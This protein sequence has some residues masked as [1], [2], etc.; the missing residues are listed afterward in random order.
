M[1]TKIRLSQLLVIGCFFGFFLF[2]LVWGLA[3]PDR[4][5]SAA[6]NRSLAQRPAMRRVVTDFGGFARDFESYAADQFPDREQLIGVYTA[7]ELA[8]GKKFA[9]KAYCLQGG[10]LL[11]KPT[12]TKPADLSALQ[13]ALAQAGALDRPLVW[14]VLPLKN[15]ALYDLEPAYFSDE[16]GKTNKQALTAALAQVEGL[17]V[18][19]AEAP[20]VTGTLADRE[21]YFY[22]TDFHWNARGAFAAAQEIARIL[23][24]PA[25]FSV[26]SFARGTV[27][28]IGFQITEQD[29]M[30]GKSL[31]EY[32]KL[33]PN[34]L[35]LCAA[36]RGGEVLVPNGHFVPQAGDRVYA[37]GTPTETARVLRSMGRD[38]SPIRQL[39]VIGGG[40]IALYLAWALDGMGMHIT[41]VEQNEEKCMAIAEKLP[42]AT[43]LHGDGT[44]HDLLESEGIFDADAFV[45]LTGRD[46][47]NLLMALTAKDSGV[48]KVLPKMSRP[49]YTALVHDLGIDTVI[50]PKD[51]TA[52]QISSYVR[53]LANSQGSAVESLHKILGGAMEAVEFTATGATH[54]LNTP[55][56]DL[57]FKPGLLVAAIVHGGKLLIPGGHSIISEG[58]RV[59]VVAKSLFL[60]DLNDILV[61]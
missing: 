52:S 37:I 48:A 23:R 3:Q 7:L 57:N 60:K 6:E 22:K 29:G 45:S 42:K 2:C 25:A 39:S 38:T 30:A 51:V 26:E 44:D 54:F 35:L 46:E 49:N 36:K 20:L 21:R 40:R 55:L 9:R 24:V 28:L 43:I 4:P 1:K 50:S 14:C 59:I 11:T 32:N 58:D 47:E 10:W 16:T 5:S 61:R 56:K 12:P 15:K 17:T 19:D 34:A 31:I 27:E 18:I 8:Q 13:Q 33:H 41:I 53:G